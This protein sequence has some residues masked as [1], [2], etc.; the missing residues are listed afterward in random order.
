MSDMGK[1]KEIE[2]L[3]AA[4]SAVFSVMTAKEYGEA[5]RQEVIIEEDL[6][7]PDTEPDMEQIFN[8]SAA[9]PGA[10]LVK[11]QDRGMVKGD[12]RV[13]ALYRSTDGGKLL[14]LEN[15]LDRKSVV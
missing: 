15:V 2:L 5:R 4:D 8:V 6:L 3:P 1:I 14:K 12:L 10:G 9:A 13:E 11:E 7:V